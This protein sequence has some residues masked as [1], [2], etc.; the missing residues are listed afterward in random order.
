MASKAK[1]ADRTGDADPAPSR[2]R[3]R[4]VL[5]ISVGAACLFV[6]MSLITFSDADPGWSASGTGSA[7]ENLGG[8]TGAFL[9]DV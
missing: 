1:T 8:V 7:V 9:A 4:D 5:F 2:R 6:L 3:V